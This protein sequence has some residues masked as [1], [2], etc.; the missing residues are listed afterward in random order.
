MFRCSASS[1]GDYLP[2]AESPLVTAVRSSGLLFLAAMLCASCGSGSDGPPED[3]VAIAPAAEAA[4]WVIAE[5][6]SVKPSSKDVTLIATPTGCH[7]GKVV[8][9]SEPVVELGAESI[10]IAVAVEPLPPPEPDADEGCVGSPPAEVL[11]ELPEPLGDRSLVDGGRDA[12]QFP[13]AARTPDCEDPVR[14][15]G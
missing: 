1:Y 10:V 8:D 5:P 14:W 6:A 11:V 13:D 3:P 7:T 4:L 12:A 9:L 15:S 2:L